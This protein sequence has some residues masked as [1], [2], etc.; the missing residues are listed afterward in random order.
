MHLGRAGRVGN[1]KLAEITAE[2][3]RKTAEDESQPSGLI[4]LNY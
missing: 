1:K 3:T 2:L 4:A